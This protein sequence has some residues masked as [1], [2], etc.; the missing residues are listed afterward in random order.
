VLAGDGLGPG[1]APGA[2]TD[3][4]LTGPARDLLLVLWGRLPPERGSLAVTGDQAAA[5]AVLAAPLVP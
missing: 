1:S 4:T 2:P 5:D 3:A